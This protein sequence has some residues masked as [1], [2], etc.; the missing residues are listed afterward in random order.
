MKLYFYFLDIRK[1]NCIC[2]EECEVTEKPTVYRPIN[3][4]P[5]GFY[6]SYV[7]KDDVGRLF[8]QNLIISTEKNTERVAKAFTCKC[9]YDIEHE[10][11]RIRLSEREIKD[12]K[13]AIEFI[14]KWRSENAE[15]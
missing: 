8:N 4:F 5:N 15:K 1:E 6:H 7:K 12:A 3:K 9:E 13:C 11:R 2:M 10:E 14:E